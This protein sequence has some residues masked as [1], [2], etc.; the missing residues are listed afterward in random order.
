M[1]TST[2]YDLQISEL[3]ADLLKLRTEFKKFKKQ[4][5]K[6]N[7]DPEAEKN[8]PLTGF[9]KPMN[10]SLELTQFLGIKP[11]E[12]MARTNVTKAIN[13]YVKEHSLQNPENKRELILDDKLRT[14]ITPKDGETVTFFNLQRYMSP[15]Y[16]KVEEAKVEEAKVEEAKV[17][18]AKVEEAKVEEV[19]VDKSKKV[20]KIIKKK[21]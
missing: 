20:K 15:H 2:D 4:V 16:K 11:D 10:L 9:S 17:E 7:K 1:A 21:A 18:E 6:M 3:K 14:I 5:T 12:L 19:K 8:K 13:S